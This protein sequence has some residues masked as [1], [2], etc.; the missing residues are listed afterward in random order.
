VSPCDIPA[1]VA[2]VEGTVCWCDLI[3]MCFITLHSLYVLSSIWM[4]FLSQAMATKTAISVTSHIRRAQ[5]AECFRAAFSK[6]ARTSTRVSANDLN[7]LVA[8]RYVR[9]S[10]FIGTFEGLG[11]VAGFIA[12]ICPKRCAVSLENTVDNVVHQL[13]NDSIRDLQVGSHSAGD[14][15]GP[16]DDA[17]ELKES[18][19]FHR[20]LRISSTDAVAGVGADS[21][22]PQISGGC[23]F[24]NLEIST[25]T[26]LYHILGLSLR[27]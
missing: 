1:G 26:V 15:P 4:S 27:L 2:G 19:K 25:S 20:D 14:G 24:R 17:M 11:M 6:S 22:A 13:L 12:N 18:L 8:E 16:G 7:D 21:E 5:A 23:V 9:P 3:R 10:V